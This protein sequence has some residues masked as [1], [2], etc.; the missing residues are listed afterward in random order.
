MEQRATTL[1]S[2]VLF[3][4]MQARSS[5]TSTRWC[6]SW[7]GGTSQQCGSCRKR[8]PGNTWLSRFRGVR[9]R[10]PNR[11]SMNLR[12][13]PRFASMRKTRNGSNFWPISRRSTPSRS[14][15]VC[16]GHYFCWIISHIT[17][18]MESICAVCS[19]SWGP[20]CST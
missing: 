10:I 18:Y 11:L 2:W 15:L 8:Y 1:S 6:K 7:D 17:A 14:T 20:T 19:N 4:Q 5:R 16:A 12:C 13:S 9:I 3:E